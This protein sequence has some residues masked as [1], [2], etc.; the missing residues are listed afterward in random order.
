[1]E[2]KLYPSKIYGNIEPLG[3]SY[4]YYVPM[5]PDYTK[6]ILVGIYIRNELTH[7]L[8]IG[9][10]RWIKKYVPEKILLGNIIKVVDL[11]GKLYFSSV[12][13]SGE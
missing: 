7:Y 5:T 13:I 9:N 4:D 8:G 6:I 3:V 12:M 10:F 2:F 11:R 1:M